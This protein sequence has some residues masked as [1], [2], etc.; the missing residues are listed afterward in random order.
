MHS[1]PIT[2]Q[3]SV[4][5]YGARF[6]EVGDSHLHAIVGNLRFDVLGATAA[7]RQARENEK[8]FHLAVLKYQNLRGKRR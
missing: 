5:E 1:N 3:V 2:E 4:L 8:A 6:G 7:Q